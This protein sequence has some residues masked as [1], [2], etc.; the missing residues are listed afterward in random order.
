L[1]AANVASGFFQG[2]P[3][4][5][6]QSRTPVAAEA[7]AKTQVTGLVGAAAIVVMLVA[8]PGLVKNLPSAAL[9][10]VV[11]AAAFGLVEY[12]GV[13][14]LY[15]LRRSEFWLSFVCFLGVAVV[16]AV[17]GILLAV[18]L[19]LA[20]FIVRSWRPYYAV[21]GRVDGRQGYHNVSRHPEARIIP[22]MVLFRW[23]ASLFFANA[24]LFQ[25]RVRRAIQQSPFR[26]QWVV[27]AAEPIT[28]VDTTA[29]DAVWELLD[30]LS[31][32]E[33]RLYFEELKG[34]V[35][36]QLVRY[37]LFSTIGE[38]HFFS[39]LGSAVHRYVDETGVGWVDWEDAHEGETE[40]QSPNP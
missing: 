35:K 30:E 1:G 40:R 39:T 27:V 26:V 37:G 19:S 32:A 2:F 22:G 36:V 17:P 31:G 9:A 21:L 18:G 33:I 14:R 34:P 29:A 4:S 6:S 38:D 12:A 10:A 7:G 8:V 16:G 13:R 20:A 28:D 25:G 3:V 11:I 24:E 5:S 23:D 15:H